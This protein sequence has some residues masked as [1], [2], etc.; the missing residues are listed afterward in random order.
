MGSLLN[1]DEILLATDDSLPAPPESG[2]DIDLAALIYTSGSSGTPKG[3][4]LTHLNMTSAAAS[5]STYLECRH[6]DVVLNVLPLAFDYGLYQ[7]F[8]AFRVGATL[9]LHGSFAYP[10]E[11]VQLLMQRSVTGFPLVPTIAAVLLR[12]DL[13]RHAF[14]CLRYV[15]STGAVLPV[16]HI[17]GL[18]QVFPAARLYS[19]YG[20]TECKRVSYLPPEQ[21][22]IRPQSVGRGMPN[23]EVYIVDE[24]GR[25]VGPRVTGELV[26]RGSHVMRGYWNLPEETSRVLRPGLIPGET[27]LYTGDLFWMDEG[28]YLYFVGRRDELIKSRGERVSPKEIEDVI[29]AMDQVSEAAVFGV[30]DAILGSVLSAVVVPREG[31]TITGRAVLRHCAL[32]LEPH[33]VPQNVRIAASIP[34]NE[35]GKVDRRELARAAV[36]QS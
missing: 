21:L 26:V 12:L 28:R 9:I 32:H 7:I 23:Q 2:I 33:A 11:I 24:C 29:T 22:D 19:M 4:M 35:R 8:L 27:V 30:P 14:P 1:L 36:A 15:T 16:N 10:W 31:Q 20:L 6:D 34:R 5:I 13:R 17:Q 3:V 18:R 25:R